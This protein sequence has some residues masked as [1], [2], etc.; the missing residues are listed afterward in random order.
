MATRRLAA[1]APA[2]V[3]IP[4]IPR[5]TKKPSQY[6][7]ETRDFFGSKLTHLSSQPFW[8]SNL[9]KQELFHHQN[10]FWWLPTKKPVQKDERSHKRS[11][12]DIPGTFFLLNVTKCWCL[13]LSTIHCSSAGLQDTV[14]CPTTWRLRDNIVT[15]TTA[16]K[17][18]MAT[19]TGTLETGRHYLFQNYP[20]VLGRIFW[21][22]TIL[23]NDIGIAASELASN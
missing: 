17:A 20:R 2:E 14:P 7:K 1:N 19:K 8:V 13:F 3:G 12:K 21:L 4:V 10:S 6:L 15:K 9:L 5:L 22:L 16:T 11:R 18:E 23:K